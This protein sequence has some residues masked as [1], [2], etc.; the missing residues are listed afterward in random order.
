MAG[1]ATTEDRP[2][3]ST[4]KR[5]AIL[6]AARRV[7]GRVGYLGASIDAIAAEAGVSTR[8]IYN[9]FDNKE[10]LFSTVLMESSTQVASAREALIDRWLTDVTDLE[11]ALIGLATEWLRPAPEFTDHFN[12]VRQ[13]KV[14]SEQFPRELRDAW[15]EAGP[16]RARRALAARMA[17]LA[18]RCRLRT[19]D[20]E[21]TAQHFMALITDT[22]TNKA[23]FSAAAMESEI[24]KIA[25]TGVRTFLYG[26][27]PRPD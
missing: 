18:G 13:L 17:E 16:L 25:R 21:T 10:Q 7:F 14:E 9:H 19:D 20:P 26:F 23:E 22:A 27:L 4:E 6:R 15:R 5:E 11:E 2:R 12:M 1:Q 3:G 8:T 24:D